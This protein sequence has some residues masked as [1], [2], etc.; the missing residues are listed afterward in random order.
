MPAA[1]L[2]PVMIGADVATINAPLALYPFL[3]IDDAHAVGA[4][5]LHLLDRYAHFVTPR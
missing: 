5:A 3:D 1:D 2:V 4:R